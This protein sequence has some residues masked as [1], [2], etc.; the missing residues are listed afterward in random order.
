[1]QSKYLWVQIGLLLEAEQSSYHIN[2]MYTFGII[3]LGFN[4][5]CCVIGN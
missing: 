3:Y 5:D 2:K 4:L 1:M